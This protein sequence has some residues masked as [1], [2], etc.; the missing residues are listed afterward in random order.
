M[1]S[2]LIFTVSLFISQVGWTKTIDKL[3]PINEY[4]AIA[5]ANLLKQTETLNGF[6]NWGAKYTSKEEMA[7]LKKLFA[8]KG[9]PESSVFPDFVVKRNKISYQRSS[10]VIE[11]DHVVINKVRFNFK[12]YNSIPTFIEGVCKKLNCSGDTASLDALFFNKAHAIPWIPLILGGVGG[13]LLRGWWQRRRARRN[14]DRGPYVDHEVVDSR[15]PDEDRYVCANGQVFIERRRGGIARIFNQRGDRVIIHPRFLQ[16]GASCQQQ[17]ALI[18][19]AVARNERN[20][21]TSEP[22]AGARSVS[23]EDKKKN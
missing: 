5:A 17:A 21:R 2:L 19:E 18:N 1:K 4:R 7:Q 16:R 3:K 6:L 20:P 9:L 13:W 8:K 22:P 14:N 23:T 11:D 15:D 10:L 12:D